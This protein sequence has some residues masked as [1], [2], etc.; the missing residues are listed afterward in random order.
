MQIKRVN[1]IILLILFHVVGCTVLNKTVNSE[2]PVTNTVYKKEKEVLQEFIPMYKS[3][4]K[5]V[6]DLIHT[7][8]KVNFDWVNRKMNGEAWLRLKPYFY[9]TDSLILDAKAMEIAKVML[10]NDSTMKDLV[11][12]YDKAFI[13]VKLPRV[14]K[15]DEEYEIYIHYKACPEE[16]TQQGSSA[17]SMAKP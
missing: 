10:V 2:Q 9:S 17:I 5:R 6:N 14:Y 4:R 12:E 11:Y 16:V 7:K 3:S 1:V 13:K 8:L 15:R